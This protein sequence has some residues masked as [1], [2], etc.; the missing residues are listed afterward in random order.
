MIAQGIT[1]ITA[2]VQ[3]SRTTLVPQDLFDF[4]TDFNNFVFT[5]S[6][7]LH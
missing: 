4:G 5:Q 3:N 1:D 2:S 6:I 7:Q